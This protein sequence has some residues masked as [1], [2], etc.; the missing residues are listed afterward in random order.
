MR[1]RPCAGRCSA[2]N[3]EILTLSPHGKG[4]VVASHCVG[5]RTACK[6][7]HLDALQ[8]RTVS[9]LRSRQYHYGLLRSTAQEDLDV[10]NVGAGGPSDQQVA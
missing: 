1:D 4:Y 6:R 2:R 3:V 9:D 10:R 5:D 7:I 8:A